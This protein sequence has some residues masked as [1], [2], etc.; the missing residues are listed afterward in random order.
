MKFFTILSFLLISLSS[1]SKKMILE[2]QKEIIKLAEKGDPESA[3]K[4]AQAY[5]KG[6]FIGPNYIEAVEWVQIAAKGKNKEAHFIMGILYEGGLIVQ[7]DNKEALYW[8]T[9]AG[10]TIKTES[11]EKIADKKIEF[12]LEALLKTDSE[13]VRQSFFRVLDNLKKEH[14]IKIIET[15]TFIVVN[16]KQHREAALES[17]KDMVPKHSKKIFNA[18]NV[19]G[20]NNS[21]TRSDRFGNSNESDLTKLRIDR[22]FAEVMSHEPE[23]KM[24]VLTAQS[25]KKDDKAIESF[26]KLLKMHSDNQELHKEGNNF[27]DLFLKPMIT[28]ALTS[29]NFTVSAHAANKLSEMTSLYEDII[30]HSVEILINNNLYVE[31]IKNPFSRLISRVSAVKNDYYLYNN[32]NKFF[33]LLKSKDSDFTKKLEAVI[34]KENY[35][36]AFRLNILANKYFISQSTAR[37]D[38]VKKAA[39]AS[40]RR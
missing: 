14:S 37:T 2:N 16:A 10:Q 17:L 7:Q 4:L 35:R 5:Y 30:K 24:R 13:E 18:L 22:F 21:D 12:L 40:K 29:H 36:E 1:Y 15:L 6:D 32:I 34:D 33:E 26:Q 27:H 19:I 28:I 25:L 23:Y 39:R 31:L 8:Y 38:I 20:K 3:F 11:A 9:K